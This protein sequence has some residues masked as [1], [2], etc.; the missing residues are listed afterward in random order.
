MPE[1]QAAEVEP[2]L[3]FTRDS[4]NAYRRGLQEVLGADLLESRPMR[5]FARR[6]GQSNKPVAKWTHT[7]GHLVPA[8]SR[9][10][11]SLIL[12]AD[13]HPAFTHIASQPFTI[14]WPDGSIYS[15]H[16]PDFALLCADRPP[17]I[18]DVKTP[19]EAAKPDFIKLHQEV[20]GVLAEAGM[21]HIVWVG[22]PRHAIGN[23]ANFSGA[24]VPRDSMAKWAPVALRLATNPL[25]AGDLA[26]LVASEGYAEGHA[27]MMIRRM[28]WLRLL[29]TDMGVHFRSSSTVWLP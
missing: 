12:L 10:E 15:S 3:A 18:V 1:R 4:K 29:I 6:Y 23:L 19:E 21:K 9:H 27:L 24:R 22:M 16:T 14:V 8:E 2:F 11:R 25:S 7:T 5:D 28:L 26:R 13:Y 17:L 20:R